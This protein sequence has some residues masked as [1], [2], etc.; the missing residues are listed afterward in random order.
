MEIKSLLVSAYISISSRIDFFFI[1]LGSFLVLDG[2]GGLCEALP[3]LSLGISIALFIGDFL[4]KLPDFFGFFAAVS[5]FLVVVSPDDYLFGGGVTLA[6][7]AFGTDADF[8]VEAAV[9]FF[10]RDD[11]AFTFADSFIL[12]LLP[13]EAWLTLRESF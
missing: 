13:F 2:V 7:E 1:F 6:G 9:S 11:E 10:E 8:L 5:F 12:I 3:S 4:S